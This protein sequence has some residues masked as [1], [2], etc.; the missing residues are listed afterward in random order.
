[1]NSHIKFVFA[2]ILSTLMCFRV[3]ARE[4]PL[5]EAGAG[6]AL[7][8]NPHYLGAE[9]ENTYLIP[10]P[11]FV[12]RGEM[13]KADRSGLRGLIYQSGDL[14][15]NISSG[16]SLPV[17]SEDNDARDGMDDLDLM[18]EIGP[19]LQYTLHKT[20]TQLLRL[21]F[22]VRAAFTFGDQFLN[23]QGWTSNPRVHY[24]TYIDDWTVTTTLGPVYSD[25]RYHGYFYDVAQRDVTANRGFYQS[26]S[27]YTG[28]RFSLS[29]NK[30][31][32]D[33]MFGGFMQYY[34]LNGA[35]NEESSLIKQDD[36]LS[37]SLFV[38]WVFAYSEVSVKD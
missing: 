28:S 22:P 23:H 8:I 27:G 16:G 32:G 15:L 4:L 12:Y 11:Y 6:G 35:A 30:R 3:L 19:T 13:I 37:A 25:S 21:D 24:S 18:A 17:N 26:S 34:N 1:M 29:V 9:Q 7:L 20:D 2:T 5:W 10:L 36:Y 14:D 33:L 38:A 31:Y